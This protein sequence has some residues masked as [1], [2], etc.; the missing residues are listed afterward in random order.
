LK[1]NIL[2]RVF[3]FFL[4]ILVVLAAMA[5]YALQTINRAVVSSDW[6]NHTYATIYEFENIS[7]GLRQS[8]GLMRTYALTGEPRDLASARE[9]FARLSER[10]DTAKALTRDDD[11][12]HQAVLR[13]ETLV[14]QR[15]TLAQQIGTARTLN[16]GDTVRTLLAAD[17]GSDA[18]ATIERGFGTLRDAQYDK[19]SERD[20]ASYRQAQTTR[21]V[22]SLGIGLN[23]ILLVTVGWLLRDDIAA[24]RRATT[25]LAE[26]NAQ[27]ENKVRDRTAELSAANENLLAENRERK[28]T[29]ASQE[30]QLRYNQLIVNSVNDLVFVLTK[31]LTITRINA[32]VVHTT[33]REDETIITRPIAEVVEVAF[34]PV[35]GLNPLARALIEGHELRQHP[36]VVLGQGKRRIPGRLTLIPLRDQDKVVGGVAVVQVAFPSSADQPLMS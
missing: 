14:Q 5:V 3:A 13:L 12:T 17:A 32:A 21:W 19:L 9:G 11:P 2:P 26:A 22:V 30:H 4:V 6:V 27:L 34:D 16:Q 33:G 36:V 18:V 23:F 7:S 10:F 8:D 24:R 1:D 20:R 25:A 29:I 31:V 28:W 35:T 15:E